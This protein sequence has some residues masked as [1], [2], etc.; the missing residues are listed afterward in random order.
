MQTNDALPTLK[1]AQEMGLNQEEFER[2]QQIIGRLPNLTE[3]SIFSVMWSE[4]WSCKNSMFWFKILHSE[5]KNVFSDAKEK[6]DGLLDLGE[7]LFCFFKLESYD[8]SSFSEPFQRGSLSLGDTFHWDALAKGV[9]Q[10]AGLS[11][12]YL[13]DIKAL[14]TR[15]LMRKLAE[16]ISDYSNRSGTPMFGGKASFYENDKQNALANILFAGIF[17]K[18]EA[19]SSPINTEGLPV[20]VVGPYTGGTH[21]ENSSI[22]DSGRQ[23]SFPQFGDPPGENLLREAVLEAIQT[24]AIVGLQSINAAG[25][26]RAATEISL[27]YKIG[28]QIDLDKIP[29]GEPDTKP[30][31]ILLSERPGRILAIGL[32]G[33]ET[34]FCETFAKWEIPCTQIGKTAEAGRLSYYYDKEKVVDLNNHY[35]KAGKGAPVYERAYKRPV[36]LKK[37]ARFKPE[38]IKK[39]SNYLKTARR[40]FS[41]PNVVSKRWFEEQYNSL[42]GA[43][44]MELPRT[45]DAALVSIKESRQA[46][47]LA[48]TGNS[49]Y[50]YADPH[51]GAMMALAEAARNII[52]SGGKPL[53]VANCLNFGSP[54]DPEIY[55]QFVQTVKGIGDFCRRFKIPAINNTVSW[56]NES[57]EKDKAKTIYPT[58]TI[59]MLGLLEEGA[60]YVS[61]GFK[62]EGVQIYMIGTPQNDMGSSE[63]LRIIHGVT[64]SPAPL[65]DLDEEYQIQRNMKIL[66]E[67]NL[68][69]SAHDVSAG[70][71]FVSL[72]ECAMV[73][74]LGFEIETDAN[75]RKD[76][77]LFGESQNRIIVSTKEE[78]EDKLVNY[79]NSNNLPFSKL[80]EA[81][82]SKAIIDDEDFGEIENWKTVYDNF[83]GE[84]MKND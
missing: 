33:K 79:L 51:A 12:L 4:K 13:T 16:S 50:A 53:A 64:F 25:L 68:I 83:I 54:Y 46:L 5:G 80:G 42:T 31:E 77:Y 45:S 40:I 84:L 55:W 19:V 43:D 6:N 69:Q 41:S 21:K 39:P 38:R 75:F 76:A 49:V 72:M 82:G 17:R 14:Q 24:G 47:A 20:F 62:E 66:I 63:Y 30:F 60:R 57:A 7:E 71:L 26:A 58:P 34:L 15:L 48:I 32:E 28:L 73:N 65:F 81:R 61:L 22:E 37:T 10:T 8:L 23:S 9:R 18:S 29:V 44:T 52:C 59:A 36:Y 67:K 1:I 35:L 56:R 70:G 2:I 11:A 74:K 27:K 78:N 3:L